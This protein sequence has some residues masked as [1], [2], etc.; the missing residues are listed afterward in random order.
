MIYDKRNLSNIEKLADNTKIAAL[1][2]HD[3]LVKNNI[4]IL[5]YSTIRTVDEQRANVKKGVSQT[6]K[7]YHIVGQAL[8]FVPVV[9]GQPKWDG[10]NDS[11]IKEAIAEAKR[12]GFEWGGDWKSFVDQPHLQYNYKGYGTDVFGKYKE[13]VKPVVK[14][15]PKPK[16]F[17]LTYTRILKEG[18]SGTDVG[19]M[20]EA[21]NKLGFN[22]G[23]VD[24]QFGSKTKSALILLQKKHLPHEV[25]GIA[26][27]HVVAKINQLLK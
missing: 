21:L 8:D 23:K 17:Q 26:A 12:L 3:Y 1:K 10:Y 22:C 20:Q 2:W 13:E 27:K 7:S 19:K 16:T 11:N 6:M 24:K 15:V 18:M 5:I 4:D 25:D 9:K 14:V